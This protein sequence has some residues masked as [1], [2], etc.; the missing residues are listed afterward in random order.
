MTRA[1]AVRNRQLALDA[2]KALLHD[3]DTPLTVEAIA[4]RA[5]VGAATVVRTFGSKEALID[6]A[7]AQ[8]LEPVVERARAALTEQDAGAALR[9]FLR[10][11]ID[12]QAGLSTVGPRLTG[13]DLPATGA[14]RAELNQA[15]VG[16]VVRAV[17]AGAIR[18]DFPAPVLTTVIW[19]TAYAMSRAAPE[20][21][22]PYLTILMDGL[23]D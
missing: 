10:D 6:A 7:V 2:T 12:F 14:R 21:A 9:D 5:G 3:N 15:A 8:L 18:G 4:R 19:E 20:L 22:E 16:L 11:M 23:R 1:D 13:M 17:E